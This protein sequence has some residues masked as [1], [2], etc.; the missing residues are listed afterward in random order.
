M[1]RRQ[2]IFI[3]YFL[4]GTSTKSVPTAQV[5]L[6]DTIIPCKLALTVVVQD[7]L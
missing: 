2:L 7:A 3:R 5:R 6:R 4:P 1:R